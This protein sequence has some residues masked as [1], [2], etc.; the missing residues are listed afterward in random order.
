MNGFVKKIALS[1]CVMFTICMV[2]GCVAAMAFVGPQYGLVMTLTLL[3]ASVAL[4]AL[5]GLWFTDGIIRRLAYPARILGFG[6]TAFA[7]LCLC[8]W[9]GGWFPMDNVWAWASFAAIFLA[10]LGVICV[11]YQVYFKATVGSF[12]AALRKYHERMGR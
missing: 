11:A 8:A 1:A 7:A 4:S 9:L 12:D 5:R 3:A 2:A 6:L 10:I